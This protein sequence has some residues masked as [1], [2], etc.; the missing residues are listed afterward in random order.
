MKWVFLFSIFL[1]YQDVKATHSKWME[2]N[3][4]S[5]NDAYP[6]KRESY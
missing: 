5:K 3:C 6:F 2:T 4:N 1:K